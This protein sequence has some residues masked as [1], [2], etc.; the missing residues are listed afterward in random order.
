MTVLPVL[1]ENIAQV[2]P[3]IEPHLESALEFS[4]GDYNIEHAK[5]YCAIGHWHVYVGVDSEDKI[6]G[7]AAVEFFNR[8]KDRIAFVVAVGGRLLAN[9]EM[10]ERFRTVLKAK[11]ATKMEGAAR[12]SAS[13]LWRKIGFTEK[14]QIIEV[15]L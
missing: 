1:T 3:E 13:R 4:K 7:A 10:F 6:L 11:G 9:P 8:P 12:E 15:S 5:V 14:Y 2:W